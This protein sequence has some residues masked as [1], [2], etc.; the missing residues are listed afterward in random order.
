MMMESYPFKGK[1]QNR[2][3]LEV[4]DMGGLE[5]GKRRQKWYRNILSNF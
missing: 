5:E 1:Q 3:G 2:R 4:K